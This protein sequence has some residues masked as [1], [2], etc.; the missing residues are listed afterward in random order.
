MVDMIDYYSKEYG[1]DIDQW[2]INYD[3]RHSFKIEGIEY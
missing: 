1:V 3:K 2:H